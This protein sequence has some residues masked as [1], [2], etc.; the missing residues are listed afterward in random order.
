MVMMTTT[1]K[2][3]MMMT[4]G[5]DHFSND[6]LKRFVLLVYFSNLFQTDPLTKMVLNDCFLK[7]QIANLMADIKYNDLLTEVNTFNEVGKQVFN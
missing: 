5:V 4:H 2:I 1:T 6:I 3:M 7:P